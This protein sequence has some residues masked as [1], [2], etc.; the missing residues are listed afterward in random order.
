MGALKNG[1]FAQ[2]W[3]YAQNFT[4]GISTICLR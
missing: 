3:R 2:T 4:I 1:L